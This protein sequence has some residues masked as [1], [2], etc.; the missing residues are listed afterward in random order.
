[1]ANMATA[2]TSTRKCIISIETPGSRTAIT[3]IT[4]RER[5][6][7]IASAFIHVP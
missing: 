7:T 4:G 1:M 5:T 3:T 2:V 6:A